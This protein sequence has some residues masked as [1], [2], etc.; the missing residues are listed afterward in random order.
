M[1]RR[2][3]LTRKARAEEGAL[4][5]PS[6]LYAAVLARRAEREPRLAYAD[7]LTEQGDPRGRFITLQCQLETLPPEDPRFAPLL[8]ES[9]RLLRDHI[10]RWSQH[11]GRQLLELEGMYRELNQ[12]W[13]RPFAAFA[14]GLVEHVSALTPDAQGR[15]RISWDRE[16]VDALPIR[17]VRLNSSLARRD[18]LLAEM[19]GIVGAPAFEAFLDGGLPSLTRLDLR[20]LDDEQPVTD[21]QIAGLDATLAPGQLRSLRASL[22]LRRLASLLALPCASDLQSLAID[23]R[24][25]GKA[26]PLPALRLERFD[27]VSD[28]YTPAVERMLEGVA[29]QGL[30]ALSLRAHLGARASS[31]F[32]RSLHGRLAGLRAFRLGLASGQGRTSRERRPWLATLD[33]CGFERLST[34]QLHDV[35]GANDVLDWIGQAPWAPQLRSLV[36]SGMPVSETALAS[37]IAGGKLEGLCQLALVGCMAMEPACQLLARMADHLPHL[38]SLT[39]HEDRPRPWGDGARALAASGLDPAALTVSFRGLGEAQQALREAFPRT[40]IGRGSPK[41]GSLWG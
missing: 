22:N 16:L 32:A 34:L 30:D 41:L 2:R 12:H 38:V 21:E 24:A 7:C 29:L 6:G 13:G 5:D 37:L 15:A 1:A 26:A 31:R 40:A 36:L 19:E 39:L 27:I 35:P 20:R 28:D 14:G 18:P 8:A 10:E 23:L 33:A 9:R 4:P 25:E 11:A 17:S 3:L